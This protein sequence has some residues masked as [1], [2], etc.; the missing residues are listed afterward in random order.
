MQISDEPYQNFVKGDGKQYVFSGPYLIQLL[1]VCTGLKQVSIAVKPPLGLMPE[2]ATNCP[3][4]GR[5]SF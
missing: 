1:Q 2:N 5:L 4:F 3:V